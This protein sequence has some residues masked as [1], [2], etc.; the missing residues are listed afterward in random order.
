ME[1]KQSGEKG[2]METAV[3][4]YQMN[5][6]FSETE[7]AMAAKLEPNDMCFYRFIGGNSSETDDLTNQLYELK[8]KRVLLIGVFRFPFRF[9]GKKRFQTATTQYFRMKELCDAVIY[10]NSDGL[11]ET[12]DTN[13]TIRDANLIFNAIEE[14]TIESLKEM[15]QMTGEMNI[16]FQDIQT[17]IKGNKGPLFLHTVEGESFDEPLKYLISTP[18]LP[19]DFTDGKQLILNIGYTRDM[20]MEAFRQINLRLHDLFSKADLFKLGSYFIDEPGERFKITLLVNGIE[21][22]IDRPSDYK[23]IPKYMGLLRKWQLLGQK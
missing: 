14:Q 11:M 19:E 8:E 4:I 12:I 5:S 15:I 17:F 9:E 6:G 1:K 21:D 7:E 16:D 22:P 18:Y 10:F 23:K 13:T 20:D 2:N 3:R